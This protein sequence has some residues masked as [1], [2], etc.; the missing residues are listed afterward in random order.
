MRQNEITM[1]PNADL[2]GTAEVNYEQ[3]R[4][5]LR[6]NWD[7]IPSTIPTPLLASCALAVFT[8]LI[9]RI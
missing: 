7:S 4:D 2:L 3:W 6:P 1:H 9:R 8:D 5:L